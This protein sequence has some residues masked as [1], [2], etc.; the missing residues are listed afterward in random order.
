MFF[1][2]ASNVLGFVAASISFSTYSH[3]SLLSFKLGSLV[4]SK[5]GIKDE[6]MKREI[7]RRKCAHMKIMFVSVCRDEFS[8]CVAQ[9]LL[10]VVVVVEPCFRR[11]EFMRPHF[12]LL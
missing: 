11:H 5:N 3:I 12:T 9:L 6:E 4:H 1:F 2:L 8:S 7:E 10:F